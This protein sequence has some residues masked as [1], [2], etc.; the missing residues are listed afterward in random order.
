MD[1]AG[2]GL[3]ILGKPAQMQELLELPT[4][5]TSTGAF[6]VTLSYFLFILF[7]IFLK[8]EE[9]FLLDTLSSL[10]SHQFSN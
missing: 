6:L 5:E 8:Y 7:N 1:H 9:Y 10:S 3:I 2:I 4:D